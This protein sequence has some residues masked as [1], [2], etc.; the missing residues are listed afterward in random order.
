MLSAYLAI[1]ISFI[2]ILLSVEFWN[3]MINVQT[4]ELRKCTYLVTTLGGCTPTTKWRVLDTRVDALH[5]RTLPLLTLIVDRKTQNHQ[6]NKTHRP[7]LYLRVTTPSTHTRQILPTIIL[8][9]HHGFSVSPNG[10]VSISAGWSSVL[11]LCILISLVTSTWYRK[12]WRRQ[13]KC[14]VRGRY[15]FSFAISIAPALSSILDL[16]KRWLI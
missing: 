7:P 15:F 12:W 16:M 10:L 8:P 11:I 3:T 14:L 6:Q 1:K 9:P 4:P 2:K 5:I 13:F